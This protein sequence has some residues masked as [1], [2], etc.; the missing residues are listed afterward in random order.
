M[1]QDLMP[2]DGTEWGRRSPGLDLGDSTLGLALEGS[3]DAICS[4]SGSWGGGPLGDL[5]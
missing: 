2:E 1:L 3:Q 5:T 4:G